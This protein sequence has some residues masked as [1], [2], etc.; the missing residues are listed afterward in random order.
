MEEVLGVANEYRAF[1]IARS[2][3]VRVR[4]RGLL[5][6]E[7]YDAILVPDM[8]DES[9]M[10]FE[11]TFIV[12]D[13][14]MRAEKPFN[15]QSGTVYTGDDPSSA[16]VSIRDA[17]G[18][19]HI[20]IEESIRDTS[21]ER[22]V[23]SSEFFGR[24]EEYVVYAKLPKNADTH[25]GC[26]VVPASSFVTAIHYRAFGPASQEDCEKFKE[27]NCGYMSSSVT[28]GGEIPWPLKESR[29]TQR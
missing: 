17:V 24:S 11:M 8:Q 4:A 13:Y 26:I 9:G 27:A 19:H 20:E 2:F 21:G 29:S 28:A 1:W 16:K 14:C 6:C 3:G 10:T 25:H 22:R 5:P 15:V 12:E 23:K 18:E 7:N